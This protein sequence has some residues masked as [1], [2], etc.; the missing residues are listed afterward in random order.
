MENKKNNEQDVFAK[1]FQ[2][3]LANHTV[4]VDASV[5]EGVQAGLKA[6]APSV[7]GAGGPVK[8]AN[9]PS[10]RLF[11]WW[12]PLSA[13]ASLALL[14]SL[15]WYFMGGE[16]GVPELASKNEI[17]TPKEN[18][19]TTLD[20]SEKEV[21][22]EQLALS[23]AGDAVPAVK[24]NAI[25]IHRNVNT[26][27]EVQA[28]EKEVLADVANVVL[29]EQEEPSITEIQ[30]EDVKP[31]VQEEEKTT[32]IQT[33]RKEGKDWT[34]LLPERKNR[35]PLLAAGVGSTVSGGNPG[36]SGL[37]YETMYE[38]FYSAADGPLR[39]KALVPADFQN[40]EY[41]PPLSLGVRMRF[42]VSDAWSLETGLQYTYLQTT[43]S[44]ESWTG[45]SADLKLH[46]LGVPFGMSVA[47][48]SS[49]K[50]ELYLAG[51]AMVEK[52]L[53]SVYNEYRDWGSAVFNTTVSSGVD[54]WQ[55]SVYTLIGAGY[56]LDKH[57]M[58]Y[59]EPQLSYYFDND[60]PLSIRTE[61]PFM[62]G[63]SAGL[64]ITF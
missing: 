37:Y 31:T 47:L 23:D 7:A 15:G 14:L 16:S 12:I 40:K 24:A 8:G 2:E 28:Q 38:N 27:A 22:K 35:K 33:L 17:T 29:T 58:L 13:A 61:M 30:A 9:P 59:L 64:R 49:P 19:S 55:W 48:T 60:Q 46:Y 18:S 56:K 32:K 36:S 34:E 25:T 52:G 51:G 26:T 44:D 6:A 50:W 11:A 45:Y 62:L 4:P 41:L 57:M 39:A 5:W 63:L 43:M 20:F 42:P 54:G 21:V 53:Y 3:K 1:A 10:R